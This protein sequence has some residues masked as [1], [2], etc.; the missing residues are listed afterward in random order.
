VKTFEAK[1]LSPEDSSAA[2]KPFALAA[3]GRDM[4]VIL[5]S[6][7]WEEADRRIGPDGAYFL[8]NSMRGRSVSCWLEPSKKYRG[9]RNL[10]QADRAAMTKDGATVTNEEFVT[11]SDFEGVYYTFTL[12]GAA[13]PNLRASRVVGNTWID[14]HVS[15]TE[16]DRPREVLQSVLENLTVVP[17]SLSAN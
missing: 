13:V 12:A 17:A 7:D 1:T 4:R 8:F 5:P 15:T 6:E 3:P 10:W 14:V 2:P 9:F 11:I 16:K